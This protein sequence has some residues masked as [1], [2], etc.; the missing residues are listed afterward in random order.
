MFRRGSMAMLLSVM[1]LGLPTSDATAK[2]VTLRCNP[3]EPASQQALAFTIDV[4]L[5]KGTVSWVQS[6]GAR[7]SSAE[8]T[9]RFIQFRALN[10]T[11]MRVD[12]MTERQANWSNG[13]WLDVGTCS[14]AENKF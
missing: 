1:L 4:D 5:T 9:D 2:V 10:G 13:A 12:R 6:P 11:T 7:E 8:V 3:D 14:V